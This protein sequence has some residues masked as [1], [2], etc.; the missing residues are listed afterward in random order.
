[1]YHFLLPCALTVI[2][3]LIWFLCFGY[4]D[5]LSVLLCV[6]VNVVT[7]ISL[8]YYIS[9][10]NSS[11]WA[12]VIGEVIVV[13]AEYFMYAMA[14]GRGKRLFLITLG[15]NLL[16]FLTGFVLQLFIVF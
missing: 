8:N 1:M 9:Y 12:V 14:Y 6:F 15:A 4:R 16:S 5:M 3:E 7:N 2:I 10:Y 11:P 13:I